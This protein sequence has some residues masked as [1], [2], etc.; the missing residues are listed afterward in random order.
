MDDW[1]ADF[2]AREALPAGFE[3]TART[4]CEP[5]ADA[6][7]AA[8]R[9]PA[10]V[11]GICGA[12]GGGK[13][14]ISAVVAHLLERRGLRTAVLSL[15]DLYLTHAER[16]RLAR[17]VHPLLITRGVPGT[18][19]TALG[20]AVFDALAGK[21]AVAL[22]SFD[23]AADDRRPPAVWPR[24]EA[25]VDVILF[26]GWCVGA[27][28][29]PP[30]DLAAP[31]NALER[32]EDPRGVWRAQVNAALAGPYAELFARIGLFVLLQAPGFEA[33]HAWRSEQEAKLR[34]RLARE[35]AA[36]GR[37]MDEAAIAHFI[38][39]YERITRW[40]LAEAPARADLVVPLGPDRRP[41]SGPVAPGRPG[42]PAGA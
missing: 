33:V 9:R 13:S 2:M 4:V 19:D 42:A 32:D 28:P 24:L 41:L 18:H 34:A 25:P 20:L 12:Q 7:A 11:V 35:G 38:A 26:E 27:R 22:P 17:D 1:L 21:G 39:H 31:V 30:A 15:D 29:Q 16:E 37:A 10:F 8:A 36:P 3:V 14:T 5:L 23:K 40:I 6:I